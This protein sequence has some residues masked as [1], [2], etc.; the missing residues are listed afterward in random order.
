MTNG[1]LRRLPRH[2]R[3]HRLDVI[4]ARADGGGDGRAPARAHLGRHHLSV[5]LAADPR[6]ARRLARGVGALRRPP[7]DRAPSRSCRSR[8]CS[9]RSSPAARSS[10]F[11][12]V[13]T[14]V[15]LSIYR[16]D[17]FRGGDRLTPSQSGF[18]LIASW[19][20]TV[21]GATYRRPRH[22]AFAALQAA[23]GDRPR[24]SPSS[25]CR[26]LRWRRRACR[27]GGVEIL[28]A[29]AG[30]GI[31]TIFP[32]TTV[33]IQNAVQPHQIGTATGDLQLLPLARQRDPGGGLRRDL[34][35]WPRSQ[36]RRPSSRSTALLAEAHEQ[37]HR[38]RR[39]VSARSSSP[40]RSTLAIAFVMLVAMEE[41][42]LRSARRHT[43]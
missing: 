17:L 34:P 16:A 38:S 9:I 31:G 33:S 41:R 22:G 18:A 42:P 6:P 8:C 40:R 37:R 2:E 32:V 23:G 25:P 35:R 4:G 27:S 11:F 3:P 39:R 10:N 43:G 12:G 14:M 28:L 7:A 29:F 13:G 15:G 20:G 30:I 24:A 21:T 36:R 26:C 5:E 19:A 1:V